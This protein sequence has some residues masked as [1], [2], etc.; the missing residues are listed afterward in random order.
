MTVLSLKALLQCKSM[1][2]CEFDLSVR[3]ARP[4]VALGIQQ[5]QKNANQGAVIFVVEVN[6]IEPMTPCLR[7]RSSPN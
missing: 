1:P 6:G 2:T 5:A 7:G 4:N 3:K